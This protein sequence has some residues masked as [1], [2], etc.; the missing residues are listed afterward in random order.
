MLNRVNPK[1]SPT[2]MMVQVFD[3]IQIIA[4]GVLASPLRQGDLIPIENS[5]NPVG[6][7]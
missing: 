1:A 3:K 6:N 2:I 5:P 4:F 7:G